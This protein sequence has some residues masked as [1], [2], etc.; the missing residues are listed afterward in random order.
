MTF[1]DVLAHVIDWLQ[2]EQRLSY[3]ALKRQFGLDDDYVEDIKEELIYSKRLAMDEDERVLVWTGGTETKP[4][5][6]STTPAQ[7]EG[8][9][10]DQSTKAAL[11][12]TEPPPPDAERR[13]LTVMF[14]DLVGSMPLSE[15]L[16]PEDYREVVRAYQQVAASVVQ[17]Y[18]GHIAQLLGD[19]LL[20]YFGWPQAHED[21]AQRAVRTGLAM[22]E[23]M[24]TLNPRL[25]EAQGIHLAIRIGIH[26][27]VAVVG[28]MGSGGHQEQ[29]AL[30]DTPN[31]ASRM[32]GM[33]APDTVTISEATYRLV[34][35]Y[36]TCQG[37]GAQTLKGVGQPMTAYRVL[38][39]SGTQSRFDVAMIRGLTPLVGRV[40][41]V[42]LLLERWAQVKDGRGQ[43][44]LLRGEG[45]IGKSRLVQVLK[46]HVAGEPHTRLECR[47]SPYHQNTALYPLLDLL[48]RTLRSQRN[49]SPAAKLVQLEGMLNQYT[50]PLEETVPLFAGLLSLP[51]PEDR[52]AP[53]NWT[54]QRQRQKT[55]EAIAAILV[56]QAEQQPVLF[57]LEDLQWT[58]PTTLEL[59][60][61][62]IDQAP[63]ASLCVLLTCRPEFHPSWQH[64]SYLTAMPVNRLSKT[65]VEQIV[66]RLT[67]GRRVPAEV[68]RQIV[69]K[70]DGVPLYVEE[71][72]KAVLESGLLQEADGHYEIVG[73]FT[74]LTIPPTLQDSLMA[75]L[76]NLMTAKVVAQLGATIG[77]QFSYDLL[78][79]VSLLN[80]TRLQHELDRLVEA[81]LLYQRGMRPHVTYV[82][83]HALIQDTA[84]RSLIKST[85]SQYH[86]RIA[87][88]LE[89]QF[90]A[91]AETQP[92]LLAYHFTE[93]GL[94]EKAVDYWHKAG[95][96]AIER[97][98]HVEAMAH[99]DR[100]LALLPTL[101]E[102]YEWVRREL[103]IR[104]TLGRVLM[105]TKG[106]GALE[107][108]HTLIR[109]RALCHQIGDHD[110]LLPVLNG[111][112]VVTLVRAELHHARAS[113][114]EWLHL[115]QDRQ[116]PVL[117]SRA[118][119]MLGET[120]FYLGEFTATRYYM[121]QCLALYD[122][123]QH[124]RSD[125]RYAGLHRGVLGLV[126]L[127]KALWILGYQD[128]SLTRI[129]E[130]HALASELTHPVSV[131]LALDFAA[132]L[133]V[134]RREAQAV[135]ARSHELLELAQNQ[136]LPFWFAW[137]KTLQGWVLAVQDKRQMGLDHMQEGLAACRATGSELDRPW[138][139]GLIAEVY[140]QGGQ[141]ED[142][143][144]V[145]A[146]AFALVDEH[147]ERWCEAE[148][149]RLKGELLLAQSIDNH[150]AAETCFHHA[151]NI[152]RQQHAKSWELRAATSLARLWQNQGKRQAASDLLTPV[153]GWFTE[154][155]ETADL[156]EAKALLDELR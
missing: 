67:G 95:Q 86:Q 97:S 152:A 98:A 121:E 42:G 100:G 96:R 133:H 68:L 103:H 122:P 154:G 48:E 50:L 140:G 20:V 6:A 66:E 112:W 135:Q 145:L 4:E 10:Q 52:Y 137:A 102:S 46:E 139:L 31:I 118:Y 39:A 108:E 43:V 136:A 84:Y 132:G 24:A 25:K 85:R 111:L 87:Q 94:H 49:D 88:V 64:R 26:T 7:P 141:A 30:G 38:A 147:D 45:G 34:E 1:Q 79:A 9:Q 91:M 78:Q 105:L 35:G 11:P 113:A 18:E 120:S 123:Q 131:A 8:T 125:L 138:L 83:K 151:L 69:E 115:V 44:V 23:A 146:E 19:A 65:Q 5:P 75:R 148:L 37:L 109:A 144:K 89:A 14:C 76:D 104:T 101:P 90:P 124:S 63:T 126:F 92:E 15:R 153:Y 59:L 117:M 150:T 77:R 22:L 58:D 60:N 71:M 74:P 110:A 119:D 51:L 130:A 129:D 54:P 143:L 62:L 56:G 27:G 36:F 33:A 114:E 28:A 73:S 81:E 106:Q 128:Q 134:L 57:I 142:G 40:Q 116:D 127:A 41:E 16:D 53:L 17:R 55:L 156:Q 93:A 13:Q 32:Q 29:L 61:L 21:D 80:E 99:L 107:V 12:P 47:S 155:F 70:T 2:R 72:T 3:R 149:H 82:F